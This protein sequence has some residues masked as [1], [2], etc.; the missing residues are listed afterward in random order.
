MRNGII[1]LV[2][3]MFGAM[4]LSG[5]ASAQSWSEANTPGFF[6]GYNHFGGYYDT[7][8]DYGGHYDYR[9]Y[10][11]TEAYNQQTVTLL[12]VPLQRR[13]HAAK[14]SRTK[15]VVVDGGCGWLKHKAHDT[16]ARKWK[17]RYEACR[18]EA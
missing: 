5:A 13:S 3:G 9:G 8:G 6:G 4:A 15:V 18:R 17:V 16:G 7:F 12:T 1:A 10:V 14:R 11:R 2:A